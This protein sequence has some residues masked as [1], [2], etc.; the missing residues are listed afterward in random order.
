M[1]III[2]SRARLIVYLVGI[3]IAL[4]LMML[5]LNYHRDDDTPI[6]F[7]GGQLYSQPL[8]KFIEVQ[9][10]SVDDDKSDLEKFFRP[11]KLPILNDRPL[12]RDVSE[13]DVLPDYL[14]ITPDD[15]IINYFSLLREAA[16]HMDGKNAGCGTLGNSRLPYPIAY[17]FLSSSYQKNISY[18]QYLA[19]HENILHTNLIKLKP[20]SRDNDHTNELKYFIEIETIKGS[21]NDASYFAYYY[22]FIN[23]SREGNLYKIYKIKFFSENYLCAPYH[24]WAYL[25]EAVVDIKYGGWCKLVKER[26]PTHQ[27]G[28]VKKIY[29]KGTDGNDY[30]IVF[31]TLTNDTDIEIAQYIKDKVGKWVLIKLDPEKCLDK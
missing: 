14:F 15:T 5:Y 21:E 12:Y 26:Y 17:R 18:E 8:E 22:G 11:S 20:I 1:K 3:I 6:F 4:T 16:N 25:G 23:L 13:L 19:S 7:M 28:Y 24:G 27:E 31:F 30:L 29:F 2:L 9:A 10:I